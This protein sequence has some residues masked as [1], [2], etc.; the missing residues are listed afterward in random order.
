MIV[1]SQSA[2]PCQL[3][4]SNTSGDIHISIETMYCALLRVLRDRSSYVIG[5][6]S[7]TFRAL[8]LVAS[9]KDIFFLTEDWN[10]VCLL[11]SRWVDLCQLLEHRR[12]GDE[13]GPQGWSRQ[14]ESTS[15]ISSWHSSFS[16]V[17][18]DQVPTLNHFISLTCFKIPG[19]GHEARDHLCQ[20]PKVG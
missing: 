14:G 13:A 4:H 11:E 19:G 8:L 10:D 3:L 12:Q 17:I 7:S 20:V 1:S 9:T 5:K 16:E 15:M 18:C 6:L 2:D